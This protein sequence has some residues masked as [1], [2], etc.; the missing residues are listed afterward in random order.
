[1]LPVHLHTSASLSLWNQGQRPWQGCD[2]Q[3][4][5]KPLL[6]PTLV[7]LLN[8]QSTFVTHAQPSTAS[9]IGLEPGGP[10][11]DIKPQWNRQK[12]KGPRIPKCPESPQSGSSG[13]TENRPTWNNHGY[14]DHN[15]NASGPRGQCAD[16]GGHSCLNWDAWGWNPHLCSGAAEKTW[17]SKEEHDCWVA[18][19]LYFRCGKLGHQAKNCL[20]E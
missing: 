15:Q 5:A 14:Q 12:V 11:L 8:L 4:Y 17:L 2:T 20:T 3:V 19:G 16:W 6:S 7:S 9:S 18:E 10:G 1:M 13:Q